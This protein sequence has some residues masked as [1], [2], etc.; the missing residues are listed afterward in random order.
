MNI[1]DLLANTQ[2]N[3][4]K[5][6]KGITGTE[7]APLAEMLKNQLPKTTTNSLSNSLG[8]KEKD[9]GKNNNDYLQQVML[10]T[11]M[12]GSKPYQAPQGVDVGIRPYL[13]QALNQMGTMVLA[14]KMGEEKKGK[15]AKLNEFSST[16]KSKVEE[17]LDSS[18]DTE[19]AVRYLADQHILLRK[20]GIDDKTIEKI[21]SPAKMVKEVFAAKMKIPKEKM[22]DKEM[23]KH[24]KDLA[25]I[26]VGGSNTM[27]ISEEKREKFFEF[28]NIIL[29]QLRA[30]K[31]VSAQD[32]MGKKDDMLPQPS[33][34]LPKKSNNP[35][36]EILRQMKTTGSKDNP[37]N[38]LNIN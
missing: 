17:I 36:D 11:F 37:L 30:D 6:P 35:L 34:F 20:S 33:G 2:F 32:F 9:L 1:L 31:K 24:A 16:M 5:I 8:V 23:Q 15:L 10:K 18:K 28:Y 13:N 14:K 38:L 21:I 4:E 22:T 12:E 26:A 7:T 29:E 25:L 19:K 3:K 27:G